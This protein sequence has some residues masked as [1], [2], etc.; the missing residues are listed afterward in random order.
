MGMNSD[1]SNKRA[2][3]STPTSASSAQAPTYDYD[4]ALAPLPV[5]THTPKAARSADRIS[6]ALSQSLSSYKS[7]HGTSRYAALG[8]E[9]LERQI[10]LSQISDG[11][12]AKGVAEMLQEDTLSLG[13]LVYLAQVGKAINENDTPAAVF[14][15]DSAGY[16]PVNEVAVEHRNDPLSAMSDAQLHA[17]LEALDGASLEDEDNSHDCVED[18]AHE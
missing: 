5:H 12:H 13:E 14:V 2:S 15:R 8:R 3:V 10:T 17:L 1:N 11:S 18:V 9:L 4:D 6:A 7:E 16:K